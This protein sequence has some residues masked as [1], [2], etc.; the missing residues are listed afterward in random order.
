MK[1]FHSMTRSAMLPAI[2]LARTMQTTYATPLTS[3]LFDLWQACLTTSLLT[4]PTN[5][6]SYQIHQQYPIH[7]I[8]QL[9]VEISLTVSVPKEIVEVPHEN[10]IVQPLWLFHRSH[11]LMLKHMFSF[12]KFLFC[13]LFSLSR[14][15]YTSLL[16]QI[17]NDK[18]VVRIL[19]KG[20]MLCFVMFIPICS[21]VLMRLT[22]FLVIYITN[23]L[24]D[25]IISFLW[26]N[27]AS[28]LCL[29]IVLLSL[30]Y[31]TI[32]QFMLP[33]LYYNGS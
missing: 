22:C 1:K 21:L 14:A 30:S 15:L 2:H 11:Q 19:E 6:L 24:C 9:F 27:I 29:P 23:Y 8:L 5:I 16:F 28:F 26:C 18:L 20:I 13:Y 4:R 32:W 10:F 25:M 12:M 7:T 17:Q 33:F 31:G 3:Q